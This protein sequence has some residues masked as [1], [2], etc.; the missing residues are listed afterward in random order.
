LRCRGV[1]TP[2]G[3]TALTQIQC[4][5]SPAARVFTSPMTPFF[6]AT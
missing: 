4:G 5:A 6:E 1:S 3:Q 2:V